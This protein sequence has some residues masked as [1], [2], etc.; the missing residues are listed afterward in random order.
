MQ[1][2]TTTPEPEQ[3]AFDVIW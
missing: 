3:I 2:A 1:M